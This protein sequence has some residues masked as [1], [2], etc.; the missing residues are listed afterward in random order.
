M[1]EIFRYLLDPHL[2]PPEFVLVLD[3]VRYFVI[4][5][6]VGMIASI[7]YFIIDTRIL[8]EKYLKDILEF[9]K[10]A[11]YKEI[12]LPKDW[13]SLRE[14]SQSEDSS[15]RKLAIIEADGMLADVLREMGYDGDSLED[16][17]EE[18]SKEI[19]PNKEDLIEAHRTRRD[20]VYDPNLNLP[21]EDARGMMDTYEETLKDL[22]LL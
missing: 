16:V 7:I 19:V 13:S 22:Q 17:L 8:E 20:L 10:V 12:N 21:Q 2:F 5:I 18:V 1:E 6:S 11:P 14:Q 3:Y 9:T 4:A 15:E